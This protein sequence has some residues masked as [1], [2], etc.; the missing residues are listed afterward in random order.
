MESTP[1]KLYYRHGIVVG[2]TFQRYDNS[3]TW[4]G[5]RAEVSRS[6]YHVEIG[7]W[8][9]TGP[10]SEERCI[11]NLMHKLGEIYLEAHGGM[12]HNSNENAGGNQ[13]FMS[14]REWTN[15]HAFTAGFIVTV[16]PL[17]RKALAQMT[18]EHHEPKK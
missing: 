15:M 6:F 5:P 18:K 2:F 13:F 8:N 14:H 16:L 12:H 17:V 9:Y 1:V 11:E 3:A 4:V 10:V 7:L